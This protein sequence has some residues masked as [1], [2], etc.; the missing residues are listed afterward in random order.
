MSIRQYRPFTQYTLR[1]LSVVFLSAFCLGQQSATAIKPGSH[2]EV[3]LN[4]SQAHLYTFAMQGGQSALIIVKQIGVDVVVDVLQP[5]GKTIDTIDSPTGRYGNE[6]VEVAAVQSGSYSIRIRPYNDKE[7][8]GRYELTF[9][10]VRSAFETAAAVSDAKNWLTSRTTEIPETGQVSKSSD[11]RPITSWPNVRVVA[12]GEAT[13]GSREFN[14][15]R[16]SVTKRLIEESGYRIVALEASESRFRSLSRYIAGDSGKSSEVTKRIETGWIGRRSQRDLIE[17]VRSWNLQHQQDRVRIIG[18]DAQDN[19][20]SRQILGAFLNKAQYGETVTKRWAE[21]ASELKAADDQTSVFGDSSVNA[22]TRQFL[23][24]LNALFAFDEPIL[25]FRFGQEFTE[26]REAAETLLEFAD[27]NSGAAAAISHSRD[28][29]MANRVLRSLRVAGSTSKA[30]YWA[31]NSHVVHPEMSN[32]AGG[33]LRQVLGCQYR[34][35]ALTFGQGEFVAQIPND[36]E[37]RLAVSSLPEAKKGSV[38]NLAQPKAPDA[39]L[40]IWECPIEDS[41]IPEWLRLPRPVHWVGGL[42]KPGSDPSEAYRPFVL[43]KDFDGIVYFSKVTAEDM[44]TDRPLV[45]ARK[46]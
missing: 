26:A 16:L 20:D 29:Y 19:S 40:R 12:L 34:A 42:W 44:P 3:S 39:F 46:H 32:T 38:E 17:W 43:P 24:E 13:H 4:P 41:A 35:L 37:D 15:F 9:V 14:S 10:A 45:P 1:M 27:F 22:S 33:V 2:F 31:H 23:L 25:A 30:I 21:A 36:L 6:V 18:L 28:W 5:G 11:L 8:S 7:P